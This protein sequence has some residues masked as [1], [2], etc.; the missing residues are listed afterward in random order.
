M[1]TATEIVT[2]FG[3]C[4]KGVAFYF[5]FFAKINT[6][7]PKTSLS[8]RNETSSWVA[9]KPLNNSKKQHFQLNSGFTGLGRNPWVS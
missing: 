5:P 3:S 7:P 6:R 2:E 1:T 4:E 8:D 9:M